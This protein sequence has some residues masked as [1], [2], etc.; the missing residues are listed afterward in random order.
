MPGRTRLSSS[1]S[2]RIASDFLLLSCARWA[3]EQRPGVLGAGNL[4]DAAE[5]YEGTED[6]SAD[7]KRLDEISDADETSMN[8]L[9]NAT[10]HIAHLCG[11]PPGL[12]RTIPT[13]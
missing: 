8:E 10:R 13:E 12:G 5:R 3:H 4:A 9:M 6:L 1:S 2:C 7:A 11:H